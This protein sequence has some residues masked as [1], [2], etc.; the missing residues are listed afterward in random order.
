MKTQEVEIKLRVKSCYMVQFTCESVTTIR[1]LL[2]SVSLATPHFSCSSNSSPVLSRWFVTSLMLA[3]VCQTKG[4]AM[5]L[6]P[7][8]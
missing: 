6:I 7:C 5:S 2:L 8:E 3:L 4:P 1:L